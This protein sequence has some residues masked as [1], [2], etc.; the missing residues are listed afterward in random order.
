MFIGLSTL[1]VHN[2]HD[3]R[4]IFL[5]L[6]KQNSLSLEQNV[7]QNSCSE[8]YLWLKWINLGF[9]ELV[10]VRILENKKGL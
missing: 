2:T 9:W 10:T 4:D 6:F 5:I 3:S 1:S 7:V 8:K